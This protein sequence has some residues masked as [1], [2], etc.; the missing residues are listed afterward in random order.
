MS[1]GV[2]ARAGVSNRVSVSSSV[3]TTVVCIHPD[4][5][6]PTVREFGA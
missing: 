2:T 3:G 4:L 6:M 5:R 1:V